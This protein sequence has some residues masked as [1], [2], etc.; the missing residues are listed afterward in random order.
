MEVPMGRTMPYSAEAEQA[1]LGSMIV[2]ASA[3]TRS[4]EQLRAE[5]F[6]LEQHRAIYEALLFLFTE[7]TPID[8]ITLSSALKDKLETAGGVSYLAHIAN[9]VSTTENIKYYLDIVYD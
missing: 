8:L 1:V 5:D 6:Y 9:N 4:V 3:L 2:S 7:N